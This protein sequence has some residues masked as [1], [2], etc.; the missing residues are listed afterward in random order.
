MPCHFSD[1]LPADIGFFVT[2]LF[3]HAADASALSAIFMPFRC[4]AMPLSPRLLRHFRHT[5][6][7]RRATL[8]MLSAAYAACHMPPLFAA[9]ITFFR[10]LRFHFFRFR[11]LLFYAFAFMPIRC[12]HFS[13]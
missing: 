13:C 8:L 5:R 10:C 11:C 6:L 1:E 7:L 4:R 9:A 12:C 3:F 2:Y